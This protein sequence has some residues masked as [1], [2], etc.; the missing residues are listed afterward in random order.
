MLIA[1]GLFHMDSFDSQVQFDAFLKLALLLCYACYSVVNGCFS[2][3][4][5]CITSS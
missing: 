3:L 5:I 4:L 1:V 2:F